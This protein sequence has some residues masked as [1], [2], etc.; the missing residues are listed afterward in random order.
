MLPAC[1]WTPA[2][3]V[4]SRRL[5][6]LPSRVADRSAVEAPASGS[7]GEALAIG[8]AVAWAVTSI[9]MRPIA[10]TALWRS[11][12]LRLA[13]CTGLLLVYAVPSGALQRA[14]TAPP[15][16]WAWLFGS[17]LC[18]MVLGDSFYF[19]ASA[20]IGVARALPIASSFPLLSTLGA[21]LFLGESMTPA[22][23][24]G[25]LLIV[26]AVALIGGERLPDG[27]RV[28]AIGLLL[29]GLAA[30]TWAASGLFLGPAL[31]MLDPIAASMVRFP[32]GVVLFGSYLLARRPRERPGPGMPWWSLLAGV[33]T[34]T[35]ALMFLGGIAGAGVARGVAL[36]ATS[37]VFSAVL[38]A[39]FL[40][41][42]VTRRGAG[43]ILLSVAGAVLLVT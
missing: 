43:G 22:L 28:D 42:R 25:S 9:V 18:S 12:V 15:V 2:P 39:L 13:V 4:R 38:A 19:L 1:P 10:E 32:I 6:A 34:M 3:A 21:I 26:V 31:Q 16:A 8:S 36:N 20:R 5:A 35:S 29:C 33:G 27:G 24:L 11:S 40:R 41:E 7:V 30:V 14:V 23:I 17:T 37:P